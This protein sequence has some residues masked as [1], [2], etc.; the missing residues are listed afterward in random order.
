MPIIF[1]S[2]YRSCPGLQAAVGTD[3]VRVLKG[4]Y[5]STLVFGP[6][7]GISLQ[8]QIIWPCL[9]YVSYIWHF[10]YVCIS[11]HIHM[12][13]LLCMLVYCIRSIKYIENTSRVTLVSLQCIF[14]S[15]L[16]H[17]Y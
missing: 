5:A 8:D 3:S 15:I 17:M 10:V 7:L 14:K 4:L 11:R 13:I 1:L 9:L 12:P 2:Y 6:V 16:H